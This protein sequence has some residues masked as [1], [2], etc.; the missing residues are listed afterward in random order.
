MRIIANY[1]GKKN[2]TTALN[3]IQRYSESPTFS[4]LDIVWFVLCFNRI[5]HAASQLPKSS[6]PQFWAQSISDPS[7]YTLVIL[8]IMYFFLQEKINNPCGF[9]L[10]MTE[11]KLSPFVK[12]IY[13]DG[14]YSLLGL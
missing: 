6:S 14:S 8:L 9:T 13:D 10:K 12:V 4:F 5:H 3:D 7:L 11:E 1:W 2:D